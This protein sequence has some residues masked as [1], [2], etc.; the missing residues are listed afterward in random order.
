MSFVLECKKVK[1]TGFVWA[2]IFGGVIAAL[3]PILN[4]V[5]RS[6]MFL[7]QSLP[8]VEILLNANWQIMSMLNVLL[9]VAGSSIIYHIEY[10]D[11]AVQ[12]MN[13]LPIL[14]EKI[15][16]NK[17]I[18]MAVMAFVTLVIE[19]TGVF[20]TIYKWFN[21]TKEIIIE[22]LKNFGY[23]FLLILPAILI[24]LF[25]SSAFKNIWMSLGIGVIFV[26]TATMIPTSNFYLSLFPYAMPFQ[27]F[28]GT[29][30]ELFTKFIIVSLC[31]ILILLF[32]EII[33]VKVRRR[34]E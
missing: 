10:A 8:P 15:F 19:M 25:I 27:I 14:E 32:S 18:L 29:E 23:S 6:D 26:F 21:I 31:E 17:F 12:K 20:F 4:M 33:Y 28:S 1:R 7:N 5:V 13:T 11:N 22:L 9:V 24:S 34:F 3:V 16:F 2:F 30:S